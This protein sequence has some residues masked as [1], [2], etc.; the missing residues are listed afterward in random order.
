VAYPLNVPT[1]GVVPSPSFP[2]VEQG[3]LAFW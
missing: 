3:I 1:D 2:A